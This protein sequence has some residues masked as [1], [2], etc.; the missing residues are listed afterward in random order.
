MLILPSSIINPIK[1]VFLVRSL[2]FLIATSICSSCTLFKTYLTCSLCFFSLSKQ[3]IIILRY[4]ITNL[5]RCSPNMLLICFQNVTSAFI[6]L[7]CI[8]NSLYSPFF[9]LKA[10]FYLLPSLILIQWYAYLRSIFIKI[11]ALPILFQISLIKGK[12]YLFFLVILFNC[13]QSIHILSFLFFFRI[14][15]T[16]YPTNNCDSLMYPFYKF[17]QTNSLSATNSVLVS[18]QIGK[19]FRLIPSSNSILQSYTVYF[20]S[21]SLSSDYNFSLYLQYLFST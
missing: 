18:L 19:N 5:L 20:N 6:S 15:N 11:F 2:H 4:T 7:N 8:T 21:L 12:G 9:N 14:N 17:S 16:G 13:L 10:T 1:L 3:I